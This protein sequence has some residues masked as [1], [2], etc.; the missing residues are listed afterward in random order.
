M[1]TALASLYER[2]TNKGEEFI[3]EAVGAR[4]NPEVF[5][6]IRSHSGLHIATIRSG[7]CFG[8]AW[9]GNTSVK[10]ERKNLFGESEEIL[11]VKGSGWDL[12]TIEPQGFAPVR[13]DVLLKMAQLEHLSD[14]DMVRE[15]RAAMINPS[16]PTP[17]VEAILHAIIPFK[18]VD[19]T[20]SDAVVALTNTPDGEAMAREVF[21]ESV[22]FLPYVMPGFVL[23]RAVF[24]K[25]RDVNW[26]KIEGIILLNHGV[27][28]F[29]NEAR[30]AYEN[31]IRLVTKAEDF[32]AKSDA[33]RI[34]TG[35]PTLSPEPVQLAKLR[36]KLS[37]AMGAP[38]VVRV[39]QSD[40]A[41]G[42]S[43]WEKAQ[44]IASQGTITPDHVIHIKPQP[45]F[46]SQNIEASVDEFVKGYHA[47]FS[48]NQKPGLKELDACP[49]WAIWPGV[50]CLSIGTSA[51]SLRIVGDIVNHTRRA[52]QWGMP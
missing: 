10:V 2:E 3:C 4:S 49:R 29:H 52:M 14:S 38:V 32:I 18:Y 5:K 33:A 51:K 43:N 17:S 13:M 8:S 46:V 9:G 27:F 6:K 34:R 50:G 40:E 21:G 31:M 12:A 48:R 37:E 26:D 1:T 35:T 23:A 25:T 42:F 7:A 28:T 19:H 47:Y 30:V 41:V 11:Y 39:D 16:A 36:Q 44:R 22:L 20:H 15:Q 24:E 45:M